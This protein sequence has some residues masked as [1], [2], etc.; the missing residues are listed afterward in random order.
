MKRNRIA[1]ILLLLTVLFLAAVL[2]NR[3]AYTMLCLSLLFPVVSLGITAFLARRLKV[4]Q[5]LSADQVVKGET[6]QF[7]IRVENPY[8]F[9]CGLLQLHFSGITHLLSGQMPVAAMPLLPL[10]NLSGSI[11][12]TCQYS[13]VFDIGI[14]KLEL[15]DYLGLFRFS[16]SH[17]QQL[18]LTVLP[19]V[20]PLPDLPVGLYSTDV[21]A[22][23]SQIKDDY[24]TIIDYRTYRPTDQFKHIHWKLSAKKNEW[25]VKNYGSTVDFSTAILLDLQ[26]LTLPL[27]EILQLEDSMREGVVALLNGCTMH[28]QPVDLVYADQAVQ[29][30]T[31]Q[32]SGFKYL[33][34]LC[35]SLTFASELP[36][37]AVLEEYMAQKQEASNY[38]ILTSS[39]DKPLVDILRYLYQ[40]GRGVTLFYFAADGNLYHDQIEELRHIGIGVYTIEPGQGLDAVLGQNGEG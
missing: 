15:T 37:S 18:T 34:S 16:A 11:S 7:H 38:W 28:D 1:Y 6:A 30:A 22:R 23:H 21:Q 35:C 25:I 14:E 26:P 8:P 19:R 17:W 33:Y 27:R 29:V 31:L 36:V 32:E 10:T 39:P 3:F 13:G 4:A 12:L 24:S 2:E 5:T 20:L 9:S 40:A